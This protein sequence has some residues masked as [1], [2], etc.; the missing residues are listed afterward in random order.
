M[1]SLNTLPEIYMTIVIE[2]LFYIH[3]LPEVERK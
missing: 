1:L 3:Y 2:A